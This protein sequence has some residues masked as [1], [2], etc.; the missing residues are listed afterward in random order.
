MYKVITAGT[1]ASIAAKVGD[2]FI[3][4]DAPA[5]VLIPSGDEVD[6]NT[7]HTHAATVGLVLADTNTGGTTGTVTYK[8]ALVN[9]TK[10]S[11]AASYT[12]GGS[13]KFYAVQLDKNGKLGTYVP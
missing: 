1:Y 8:A 3:C 5:W 4:S 10:S 9:E 12:A 11:N 13:S 2:V 7:A 6:T